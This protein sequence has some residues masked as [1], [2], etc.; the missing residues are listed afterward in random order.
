MFEIKRLGQISYHDALRVQLEERESLKKDQKK[1][2]TVFILEHTPVIT[3][4]KAGQKNLLKI[5][6]E[7]EVAETNRGGD[8]TYHGPGQIVC[9][10][11]LNLKHFRTDVHWYMRSLEEIIIQFL[12]TY[13]VSGFRIQG[14]TGVWLDE[15]KKIG[16]LGVHF[17]RWIS[18][19]GFSINLKKIPPYGF[20][21]INPC[22]F[23]PEIITW[24]EDYTDV[25]E[26]DALDRLEEIFEPAFLSC[27]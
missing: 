25:D 12:K 17:S 10:P 23:S 20:E 21:L 1:F 19:H 5:S 16:S 13:S 22:G 3:V 11:V 2:G 15:T 7:V 8:V 27:L 6:H 9:Y 14:K 4:T 18:I 24:L 26:L